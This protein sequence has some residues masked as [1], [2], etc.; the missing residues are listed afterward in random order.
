MESRGN[1]LHSTMVSTL[2]I[3][4]LSVIALAIVWSLLVQNS[5]TRTFTV[6]DWEEKKHPIDV[7]VFRNLV[8][9]KEEHYL[10]LA[11][12]LDRFTS[13]HRR[14]TRLALRMVILAKEN[15]EMLTRLAVCAKTKNDPVLTRE[16]ERLIAAA[17]LLRFNLLLAKYCL[18]IRWA[19][20]GSTFALPAVEAQYHKVIDSFLRVQQGGCQT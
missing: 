4:A 19:F 3:L 13:F 1:R 7:Q 14:R 10:E 2:L 18:C 11:L 5:Q 12:P 20:P 15:A 17:T 16:A 8:D 9:P 6:R